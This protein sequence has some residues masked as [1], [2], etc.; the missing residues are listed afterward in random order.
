M[1]QAE[2]LAHRGALTTPG[3]LAAAKTTAD[4]EMQCCAADGL[5]P[6]PDLTIR[7]RQPVSTWRAITMRWIWFVPS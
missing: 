3:V 5:V 1:H 7:E 6:P 4:D 2:E